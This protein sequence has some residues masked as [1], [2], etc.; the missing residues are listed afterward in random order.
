[1]HKYLLTR[2][3]LI[4]NLYA[5]HMDICDVNLVPKP[6]EG[7][8]CD[9]NSNY[10]TPTKAH[11][12]VLSSFSSV[13][14]EKLKAMKS[15]EGLYIVTVDLD[16]SLEGIQAFV[17]CLYRKPIRSFD[18]AIL[19]E[20]LKIASLYEVPLFIF[21]ELFSSKSVFLCLDECLKREKEEAEKLL[22]SCKEM[23]KTN[24]AVYED[25]SLFQDLNVNLL[26]WIA[27][28]EELPILSLD[29]YVIDV[30]IG[31]KSMKII[32]KVRLQLE[33][34]RRV[35]E[36]LKVKKV[37]N[38]LPTEKFSIRYKNETMKDVLQKA[39]AYSSH[40]FSPQHS[41]LYIEQ[42]SEDILIS[43]ESL[44]SCL[45]DYR[46]KP[47]QVVTIEVKNQIWIRTIDGKEHEILI[48]FN[49]KRIR[50]LKV[51]ISDL[52]WAEDINMIQLVKDREIL[53]DMKTLE[54]VF[55]GENGK[56][57][58]AFTRGD[59]VNADQIVVGYGQENVVAWPGVVIT[60][61]TSAQDREP[62]KAL[63]KVHSSSW[64]STSP[65]PWWQ[66]QF[67]FPV[68]LG[69]FQ[70]CGSWDGGVVT[71]FKIEGSLNED[72]WTP[73][74]NE[75][76]IHDRE[77]RRAEVKIFT[78]QNVQAFKFYRLTVVQ[79]SDAVKGV[80]LWKLQFFESLF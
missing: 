54:E 33:S 43:S 48:D 41:R 46:I 20:V 38:Y 59:P 44:N 37:G 53:D 69:S 42:N 70:F 64:G 78:C 14:K 30:A 5:N 22:E 12:S 36:V 62:A 7:A 68:I 13:L 65:Q 32:S 15:S 58:S 16:V 51:Q 73:V 60:A 77:W 71:A 28:L 17:N 76:A 47:G 1:M 9:H 50:D 52:P 80:V 23:L 55:K 40:K 35:T 8:K 27:D 10:E 4:N 67:Q 74:I 3:E 19:T 24:Y 29:R 72:N 2:E 34:K 11:S 56:V 75:E 31:K 26:K 63:S 45:A 21:E 49:A 57:L 66:C 61:M 39:S 6:S 18:Q 79:T 25:K